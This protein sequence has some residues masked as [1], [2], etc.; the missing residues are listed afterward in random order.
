MYNVSDPSEFINQMVEIA[1]PRFSPENVGLLF[2]LEGRAFVKGSHGHNGLCPAPKGLED[3]HK[4][5]QLSSSTSEKIL[6][7][8]P[9]NY[10]KVLRSTSELKLS[11][12]SLWELWSDHDS[13]WREDGSRRLVRQMI[14]YL[15]TQLKNNLRQEFSLLSE[16]LYFHHPQVQIQIDLSR[17]TIPGA[18]EHPTFVSWDD[19]SPNVTACQRYLKSKQERIHKFFNMKPL[20]DY[21]NHNHAMG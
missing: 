18:L 10:T 11:Q 6:F 12:E 4:R 1:L 15:L 14:D 2:A 9:S 20:N 21:I 7:I 5:Q 19:T 8:R 16:E 3:F 13:C 17:W